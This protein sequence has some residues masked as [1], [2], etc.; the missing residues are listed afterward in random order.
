MLENATRICEA[1]FGAMYLSAGNDTFRIV[2]THNAPP[3]FAEMR[4]A[5]HLCEA[6]MAGIV[7]PKGETL[8]FEASYGYS[9]EFAE[10]YASYPF[11]RG[12]VSGRALLE[13]KIVHVRDVLADPEYTHGAGQKIGGFRTFLGV[14]L[15]R[16]GSP[17]TPTRLRFPATSSTLPIVPAITALRFSAL[18]AVVSVATVMCPPPV[19]GP[20]CILLKLA[21]HGQGV[22]DLLRG[23]ATSPNGWSGRPSNV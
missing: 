11:D 20:H 7:R 17:I 13:R 16:E 14:P 21:N 12:T 4:T 3:A 6:D 23:A 22:R 15:L 10:F 2:A 18:I 19:R 5:A 1:K 8:Y 9:R